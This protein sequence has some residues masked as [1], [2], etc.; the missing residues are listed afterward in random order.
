MI[1]FRVALICLCPL[2]FSSVTIADP[3]SIIEAPTLSGDV[4]IDG[5]PDDD[6]WQKAI[7][8]ELDIK[9]HSANNAVA[10]VKLLPTRD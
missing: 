9:T 7:A 1:I 6:F 5:V 2:V 4:V 10:S 8:V 3:A